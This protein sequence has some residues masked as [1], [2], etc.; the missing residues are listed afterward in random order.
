MQGR[1]LSELKKLSRMSLEAGIVRLRDVGAWPLPPAARKLPEVNYNDFKDI[2]ALDKLIELLASDDKIA[3][4]YAHAS[5][6]SEWWRYFRLWE[7]L[8]VC[9]L[10]ETEDMAIEDDVFAKWYGKFVAELYTEVAVWRTIDTVTGLIL[11]ASNLQLDKFT[12]LTSTPGWD[13][14][15]LVDGQDLDFHDGFP[16]GLDKATIVTTLTIPKKDYAGSDFAY[17]HLLRIERSPAVLA[18]IRLLKPGTPRL[19][20][21]VTVQLSDCPL[22]TPLSYCRAD[23]LPLLYEEA[24]TLETPDLQK[25]VELWHELMDTRY[26]KHLP[27]R[28]RIDPMSMAMGRFS[29]SYEL[30]SWL[31]DI[32]DLTIALES[33]FR[34]AQNPQQEIS[35]RIAMYASWLLGVDARDSANVFDRVRTMYEIRSSTVHG[36]TPAE[37]KMERWL[38]KLAGVPYDPATQSRYELVEPATES[39]RDVV[40]RAI[41]ACTRLS[42]LGHDGPRWPFPKDFD[43]TIVK[44]TEREL[45]Q[46]AAGVK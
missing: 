23:G 44:P 40:R 43:K 6:P 14:D 2:P 37:R 4:T 13:L 3:S 42:K 12:S 1:Q 17:P 27:M 18:A 7:R 41:W 29:R 5:S 39:A 35:Y 34:P 11:C 8:F 19:H 9:V 32:V 21:H 38:Q 10:K 16:G 24:T 30:Q 20:C 46:K 15:L 36:G 25:V 45:W 28:S 22:I 33:L 31:D 26:A